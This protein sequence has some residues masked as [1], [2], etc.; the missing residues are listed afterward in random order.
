MN[1]ENELLTTGDIAKYCQVSPVTVFRWIKAGKLKAYTTPGGHYRVRKADFRKFLE[2]TGMPILEDFFPPQARRILVVDDDS[3]SVEL[4]TKTLQEKHPDWEFAVA[5]DAFEAGLQLAAF[6]PHLLILDLH[7][8]QFGGAQICRTIKEAPEW[9]NTCILG[10]AEARSE[11][12]LQQ[13]LNSGADG[14]L[15]RPLEPA[16]LLEKVQEL[17]GT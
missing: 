16:T 2:A 8:S 5:H 14:G 10:V 11:N 4:I 12:V 17:L 9:Q 15:M 7:V 3:A 1:A 13:A 6:R